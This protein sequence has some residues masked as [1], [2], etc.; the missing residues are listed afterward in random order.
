MTAVEINTENVWK[1]FIIK[2]VLVLS[3]MSDSKLIASQCMI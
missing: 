1:L 3:L 2:N